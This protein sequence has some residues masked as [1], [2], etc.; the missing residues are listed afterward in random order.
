MI[1]LEMTSPAIERENKGD[2]PLLFQEAN[3]DHTVVPP[4]L[5]NYLSIRFT[6]LVTSPLHRKRAGSAVRS[7]GIQISVRNLLFNMTIRI[8]LG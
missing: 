4:G 7:F 6:P 2:R 8:N 1:A 3:H 5:S